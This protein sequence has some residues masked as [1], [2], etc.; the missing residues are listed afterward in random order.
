MSAS[1]SNESLQPG[2]AVEPAAASQRRG[3]LS[4]LGALLPVLLL[5]AALPLLLAAWLAGAWLAP[6]VLWLSGLAGALLALGSALALRAWLAGAFEGLRA[7][8]VALAALEP[9][10]VAIGSHGGPREARGALEALEALRLRL[11]L[12]LGELQ[13]RI[14]HWHGQAESSRSES[15]EA[16]RRARELLDAALPREV[17]RRLMDD[18]RYL[19][20][21]FADAS[22]IAVAVTGLDGLAISAAERVAILNRV[23]AE[24]DRL[25][26]HGGIEKLRTQGDVYLAASGL[27][28]ADEGHAAR[29]LGFMLEAQ[30]R[31]SHLQPPLPPGCAVL[32][33]AEC[34]PVAAGIVGTGHF[35]YDV[36]GPTA[37]AVWRLLERPSPGE[38][39]VGPRL[40]ARAAEG[41]EF[42]PADDAI[43]ACLLLRA[44]ASPPRADAAPSP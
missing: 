42:R 34:G 9:Q 1:E 11:V 5:V 12:R 21:D 25:A 43:D 18:P 26:A 38:L 27:P 35:T 13:R 3:G 6:R 19:G 10:T 37:A 28:R 29:A 24:L 40:A 2:P 14:E 4:L 8:A 39:R 15:E 16:R 32:L 20:E 31:L 30:Q 22:L 17:G 36:W 44:V 7:D 41:F 33:A 23:V